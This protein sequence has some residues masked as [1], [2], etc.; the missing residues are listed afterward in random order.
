MA[1]TVRQ[2]ATLSPASVS[3]NIEVVSSTPLLD[4]ETSEVGQ[5]VEAKQITELPLNGRDIYNLLTLTAGIESSPNPNSSSGYN[6]YVPD[7]DQIAGER[8]GYTV[9]R[10]DSLNINTQDFP[11]LPYPPMWMPCRSWVRLRS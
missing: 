9:F 8:A 11:R 2:D 3:T 7:A 6:G 1:S 5:L 10:M 4:K